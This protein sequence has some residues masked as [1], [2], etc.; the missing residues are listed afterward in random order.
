MITWEY[1]ERVIT[2]VLHTVS[3]GSNPSIPTVR[4]APHAST[5][6]LQ[7]VPSPD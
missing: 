6:H 5:V 1:S 7:V 3:L 2:T 4:D